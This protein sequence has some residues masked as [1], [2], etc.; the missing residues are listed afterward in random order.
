M[1]GVGFVLC[2]DILEDTL[3][4]LQ[5]FLFPVLVGYL[6]GYVGLIALAVIPGHFYSN[7]FALGMT[8]FTLWAQFP[9]PEEV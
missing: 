6:A 9:P 4:Q 3:Y 1:A 7:F 5:T 2:Y 8:V